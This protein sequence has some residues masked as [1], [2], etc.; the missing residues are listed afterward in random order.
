MVRR[1]FWF[2]ERKGVLT[3]CFQPHGSI[4]MALGNTPETDTTEARFPGD[5]L[6]GSLRPGL[7]L[8]VNIHDLQIVVSARKMNLRQSVTSLAHLHNLHKS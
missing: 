2:T 5:I 8:V 3:F 6:D 1:Q 4:W 7:Y